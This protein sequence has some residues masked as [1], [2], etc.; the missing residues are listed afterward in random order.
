MVSTVSPNGVV[1]S[2]NRA[3]ELMTGLQRD[4]WIGKHFAQ[5]LHPEDIASAAIHLQQTVGGQPFEGGE[6]RIR[7]ATGSYRIVETVTV[8]HRSGGEI[9]GALSV[10]HDVTDVRKAE[11][12][13]RRSEARFR[14]VFSGSP[15]P[16]VFV[17][18][19]QRLMEGNDAMCELL[20]T[21]GAGLCGVALASVTSPEDRSVATERF[22]ELVSGAVPSYRLEQRF[23][24]SAG[25]TVI[26]RVSASL[27]AD[28]HDQPLHAVLVIE[29]LTDQRVV[30]QEHALRAAAARATLSA[31][32]ARELEVLAAVG[33]GQTARQVAEQLV[34]S[35]RT[36]ESHVATAYKKLGV[37]TKVDAIERYEQLRAAV[38]AHSAG[39]VLAEH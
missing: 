28:D 24:T 12:S 2:L 33:T 25:A 14:T 11:S 4:E 36:V 1:T 16:M 22:A 9:V 21:T 3:F 38:D 18:L 32:T 6:V 20:G 34:V 7:T 19:D 23:V 27:V 30:D 5:L 35:V 39:T 13:L 37:R 10:T 26:G 15:L 17:D 29:D 8:P 31:L